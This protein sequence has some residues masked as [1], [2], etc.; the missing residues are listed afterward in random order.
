MIDFEF[1]NMNMKIICGKLIEL[2]SEDD[3]L[4]HFLAAL[5]IQ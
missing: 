3:W 5:K 1:V 2:S 4:R